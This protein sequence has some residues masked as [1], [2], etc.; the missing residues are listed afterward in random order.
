M[1]LQIRVLGQFRVHV[2]RAT[3]GEAM[4]EGPAPTRRA[5]ELLQ[6]LCLQ[7]QRSLA[8]EQVVE[9][10]WPHLAPGAGSANLRKA[11]FHARQFVGIPE[12]VTLRGGRVFLMPDSAVE[13]DAVRF[14]AAA[15]AALAG[16]DAQACKAA[17]V[18]YGGDLLPESRYEPWTEAPRRRL[19]DKYLLLLRRSGDLERLVREDPTNEEAHAQLMREELAAGRRSS[20]LRWYS[21]LRDHLQQTL[22][23]R[24]GAQV[25]ALYRE[26]V[27]GME[28]S[29][30]RFVGRALE[31]VRVLAALRASAGGR[32]GG[33]VV[34]AAA[35]MGK[36]AFCRRVAEEARGFGWK[37]RLVQASDWTRPYGITADLVQP[38]VDQGPQVL[39]DVGAHAR[40]VLS[41]MGRSGSEAPS[42]PLPMSRHQVVGAV[43]R[44]LLATADDK[45]V[46]V[47][48]DDAHAA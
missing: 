15:D 27:A 44:L 28:G 34:R 9:A 43:R 25:E 22:A 7:P 10:L 47:I 8:N 33:C 42:L 40:A 37:V 16:G 21:H 41:A 45:P 26:C 29:A 46:L 3:A 11:A 17:T 20:A 12:V 30:P 6:L 2:A 1:S 14:E 31:L 18:L 23:M 35:G 19:R 13:C 24:P 32:P 48:V 39:E 36:T 4:H 5:A 38:L